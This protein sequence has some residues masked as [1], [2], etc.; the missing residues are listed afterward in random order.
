[1]GIINSHKSSQEDD[2]NELQM[3][4]N[5]RFL[6]PITKGDIVLENKIEIGSDVNR[7]L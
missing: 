6:R 5:S 4:T 1:M 2:H 7:I 3:D